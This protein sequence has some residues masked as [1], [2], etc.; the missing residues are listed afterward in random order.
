MKLENIPSYRDFDIFF[1]VASIDDATRFILNGTALQAYDPDRSSNVFAF[2]F[3]DINAGPSAQF[4]G[5]D[6]S[7]Y[8]TQHGATLLPWQIDANTN[9]LTIT[10]YP[11]AV[12]QVV[13]GSPNGQPQNL[14]LVWHVLHATY[15]AITPIV[16]YV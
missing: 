6:T 8:I 16:Q 1:Q 9:S 13:S 12:F 11:N 2:V 5:A 15:T 3:S 10:T 4:V 7:D 14:W